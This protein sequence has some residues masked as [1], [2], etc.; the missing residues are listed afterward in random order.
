LRKD[1]VDQ[2]IAVLDKEAHDL[3]ILQT[4][5]IGLQRDKVIRLT[6][7]IRVSERLAGYLA[8]IEIAELA[9][10]GHDFQSQVR[11]LSFPQRED[12]T[13]HSDFK[14]RMQRRIY[15]QAIGVVITL[16]DQR[17]QLLVV[18]DR[19]AATFLAFTEKS[20]PEFFCRH[21]GGR[22]YPCEFSFTSYS[23]QWL[24]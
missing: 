12:M 13:G 1:A 2:Q 21:K 10:V 15:D 7:D 23:H 8:A 6:H 22:K 18:A 16:D 17:L 9:S 20:Y 4:R 11:K 19:Q 3:E 5:E 24:A 14:M